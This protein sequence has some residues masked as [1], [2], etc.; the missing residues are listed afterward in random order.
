VAVLLRTAR[1]PGLRG[2]GVVRVPRLGWLVTD[3]VLAR[4]LLNDHAHVSVLGE[5][6]I[7]HLW[8]QVLG[9]WVDDLFDGAG[10]RALRSRARDLFTEQTS[11]ALVADATADALDAA[12]TCL[13]HGGP[14]DVAALARLMV[15]RTVVRLL[16]L[17]PDTDP[18]ASFATA[19]ELAALALGT[20]ASTE[21]AAGTVAAARR[22]VARLTAGVESG[23]RDGDPSTLLGR[24]RELGLGLSETSGLATLIVVAGTGTTASALTRTVALLA[25]TGQSARLA[26]DPSLVPDAVREGLRVTTAAPVIGRHVRADTELA[27]HRLR[28]GD[29]VLVL[30]WTADNA[31]GPLDLDRPYLPETRQLW[32]GAGRHLCLGAPVARAELTGLV[33]ALARTGRGWHV[34]RRRAAHRV[35]VPTYAELLVRLD[36]RASASALR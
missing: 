31:V 24:C 13:R 34:V 22:L 16:G 25:D 3:P 36:P 17:P 21:L 11:A 7:G 35:L 23:W 1:L 10:H 19:E 27:G 9:P 32:F 4:R 5:G 26:A 18:A 12:T 33:G 20:A 2:D 28:R 15:G 6:G 29:R 14:V 30:A 8:A